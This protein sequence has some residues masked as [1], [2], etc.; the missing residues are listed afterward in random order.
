MGQHAFKVLLICMK[1][2]SPVS[3]RS[4]F[5]L[6]INPFKPSVTFLIETSHLFCSA[7]QMTGFFVKRNTGLKW[8]KKR[9]D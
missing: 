3:F 7:K 8:V 2:M 1:K 9:M 5:F 6:G 4:E